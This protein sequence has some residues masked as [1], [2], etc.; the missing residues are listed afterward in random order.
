MQWYY[1]VGFYY[2]HKKM[3]DGLLPK[4]TFSHCCDFVC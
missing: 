2:Q 3:V 1:L 4:E